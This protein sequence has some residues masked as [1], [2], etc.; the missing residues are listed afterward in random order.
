[1]RARTAHVS[2]CQP[3][4]TAG[5]TGDANPYDNPTRC[6]ADEGYFRPV[7]IGGTRNGDRV[8]DGRATGSNQVTFHAC[9]RR[10]RGVR[11]RSGPVSSF[12]LGPESSRRAVRGF[13]VVS[14]AS[15]CPESCPKVLVSRCAGNS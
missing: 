7:K 1:V 3:L 13:R 4:T 8:R 12:A 9:S 2:G 14:V 5:A 11:V 6:T 10:I 15:R